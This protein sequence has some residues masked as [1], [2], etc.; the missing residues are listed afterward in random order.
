MGKFKN[1]LAIAA[2]SL[3]IICI[4]TGG[5]VTSHKILAAQE[6]GAGAPAIGGDFTL[7]DQNGRTRHASDFRGRLMLIYFGYTH[8]PTVCPVSVADM[9][10]AMDALGAKADDV[11]PLFITVDP[12]R[13]TPPALKNYLSNFNERMIGLT[14]TP[15]QI[16]SVAA[17]YKAYFAAQGA[18]WSEETPGHARMN[19]MHTNYPVD[20]SSFIYL[21]DKN[22]KYVQ[23]FPYNAGPQKIA[24]AITSLLK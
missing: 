15:G 2:M 17:E 12:T 4:W 1:L 18:P 6:E 20:H 13:D 21:M 23:L 16:K 11:A 19:G 14:G 7:T 9:S 8:C 5:R 10:K 3:A 22:G 24:A